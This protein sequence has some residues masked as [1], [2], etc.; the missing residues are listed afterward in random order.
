MGYA[1]SKM[2]DHVISVVHYSS[3]K[4]LVVHCKHSIIL[5]ELIQLLFNDVSCKIHKEP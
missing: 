3:L 4:S 1:S 5:T 2:H